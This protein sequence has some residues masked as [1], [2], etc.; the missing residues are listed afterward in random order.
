MTRQSAR[1]GLC[2]ALALPALA[3]AADRQDFAGAPIVVAE[4][5]RAVPAGP[6]A[7]HCTRVCTK[8]RSMGKAAPPMCVAWKTVC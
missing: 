5:M 3:A 6:V 8:T 1:L 2:V 7:T 4:Y